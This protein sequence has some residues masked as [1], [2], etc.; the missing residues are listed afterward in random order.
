MKLVQ[1]GLSIEILKSNNKV[2]EDTK[3]IVEIHDK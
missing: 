2:L 1:T 3:F